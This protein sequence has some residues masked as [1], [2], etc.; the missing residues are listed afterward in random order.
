[1]VQRVKDYCNLS[2]N[3]AVMFQRYSDLVR[4]GRCSVLF[5]RVPL[6]PLGKK[7]RELQLSLPSVNFI[8][9][10]SVNVEAIF[11]AVDTFFVKFLLHL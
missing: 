11:L 3:A 6:S 8:F 4:M 1:M 7:R 10:E 9:L 2:I 5:E